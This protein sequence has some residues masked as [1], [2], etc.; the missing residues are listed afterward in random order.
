MFDCNS[1]KKVTRKFRLLKAIGE[2][3]GTLYE[4]HRRKVNSSSHYLF[5][6]SLTHYMYASKHRKGRLKADRYEEDQKYK[7]YL[8]RENWE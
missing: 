6:G 7:E 4:K 5:K 3:G 1:K 8:Q 2:Q